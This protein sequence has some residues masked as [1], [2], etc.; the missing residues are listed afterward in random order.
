MRGVTTAGVW[1]NIP[2]AESMPFIEAV[3]EQIK[4]LGDA[5]LRDQITQLREK[6]EQEARERAAA[7]PV[8]EPPLTAAEQAAAA[9]ILIEDLDD[10]NLSLGD[11]QKTL[12]MLSH[13][14]AKEALPSCFYSPSRR[15]VRPGRAFACH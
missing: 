3:D 8:P 2:L 9:Q 7:T 12:L 15:E 1:A 6:K 11:R 5:G 13:T 10:P 4:R 14:G